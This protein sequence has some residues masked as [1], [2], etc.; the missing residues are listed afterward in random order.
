MQGT[1]D[2]TPGPGEDDFA[3]VGAALR[4]LGQAR[5]PDDAAARLAARLEADLGP[6]PARTRTRRRRWL[7]LAGIAAPALGAAAVAAVLVL[8]GGDGSRPAPREAA[9]SAT[10]AADS[11]APALAA[12]TTA[13]AQRGPARSKLA[14][15]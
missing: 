2:G 9:M 6:A 4:A 10:G 11:A 7:P 13:G 8:G 12:P 1:P 14:Q 3:S 5:V 15:V